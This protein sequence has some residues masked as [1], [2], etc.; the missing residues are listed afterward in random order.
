MILTLFGAHVQCPSVFQKSLIE[1]IICAIYF[2][3]SALTLFV[4]RQ[5][6][7]WAC[8]NLSIGSICMIEM[9]IWLDPVASKHNSSYVTYC[10]YSI[11]SDLFLSSCSVFASFWIALSDPDFLL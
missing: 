11:S 3:F 10:Y 9:M 6:E 1:S 4:G 8:K 7:H 2:T 5:E